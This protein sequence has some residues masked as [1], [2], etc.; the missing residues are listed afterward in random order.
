MEFA[1]YGGEPPLLPALPA[2]VRVSTAHCQATV[3]GE[4]SSS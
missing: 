4:P 2:A 1:K 3:N